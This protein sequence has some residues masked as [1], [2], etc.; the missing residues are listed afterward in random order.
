MPKQ[1]KFN[2]YI[3]FAASVALLTGGVLMKT[4]PLLVFSGIAPLFAIADKA[5][6]EHVW[7]KVELAGVSVA[8]MIFAWHLFDT[9]EMVSSI[10]QAIVI[11]LVFVGH[12]FCRQALGA[13]F[14]KL[15]LMLFWLTTEYL[16]LKV[17]PKP[18]SFFLGDA[19]QLVPDWSRWTTKTGYLGTS[20]WILTANLLLYQGL[21]HEKISIPW[22]V[23]FV[24]VI[25]GPIIYSYRITSSG[26]GK[27]DMIALY[28]NGAGAKEY[29][30]SGE[31]VPR[32]AAWVSALVMLL[33]IVRSNIRKK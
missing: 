20:L 16:L 9:A 24:I 6:G 14:G 32:T 19:L 22:L 23:L 4:F 10:I 28:A 33:A 17:Y 1:S 12:A 8:V 3:L 21:L 25:V 7:S 11:A 15:P 2:P 27:E 5:E 26:I 18:G 29:V 13:R 31:W 30:R